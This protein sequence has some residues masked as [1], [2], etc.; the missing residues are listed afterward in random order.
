MLFYS[1]TNVSIRVHIW[2][3]DTYKSYKSIRLCVRLNT[4]G[5]IGPLLEPAYNYHRLNAL[6]VKE[7][8]LLTNHGIRFMK[9]FKNTKGLAGE[10]ISDCKD[11]IVT[12]VRDVS[13]RLM[14]G[15]ANLHHSVE[16]KSKIDELGA[17]IQQTI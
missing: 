5:I 9:I 4:F 13:Y 6:K 2:Y 15:I 11:D 1:G 12:A 14:F 7:I 3:G 16:Q 10:V 8:G 17:H